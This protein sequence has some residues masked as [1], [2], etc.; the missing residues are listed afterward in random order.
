MTFF[1]FDTFH[2]NLFTFHNHFAWLS[3]LPFNFVNILMFFIQLRVQIQ[4]KKF[5]EES[6]QKF[7]QAKLI[8]SSE[9]KRKTQ[10]KI[11]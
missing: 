3:R 1:T 7:K 11:K 4:E 2:R 8:E 6:K 10:K 9:K 5:F